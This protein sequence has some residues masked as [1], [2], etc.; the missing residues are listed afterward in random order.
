MNKKKMFASGVALLLVS[1]TIAVGQAANQAAP[2]P[3]AAGP[4][5]SAPVTDA[6][7][8]RLGF[9]NFKAADVDRM[10]LTLTLLERARSA[11]SAGSGP[12]YT[13]TSETNVCGC[14]SVLDCADMIWE[15]KTPPRDRDGKICTGD[16]CTCTWH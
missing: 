4:N 9:R 10:R 14:N 8:G 5:Y 12:R 6:E 15:C 16:N 3:S 1:S 7:L 13:C 11:G 2:A